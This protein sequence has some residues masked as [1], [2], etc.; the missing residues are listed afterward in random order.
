MNFFCTYFDWNY[1]HKGLVMLR[2]L[3]AQCA[4]Y[5]V[6]VLALDDVIKDKLAA[7][8]LPNVSIIAMSSFEDDELR[9]TRPTRSSRE[10]YWT[11]TPGWMQFVLQNGP[12]DHVNYIDADLMFFSD[13]QP[14]FDEIGGYSLAITP[15]DFPSR[16]RHMEGNGKY[17]V[18]LVHAKKD[19]DGMACIAEWKRLCLEWCYLRHEPNRPD[20]FCDQKYWDSVLEKRWHVHAIEHPGANRAPWNAEHR[21]WDLRGHLLHIDGKPLVWWHYHGYEG[22]HMFYPSTY[23]VSALQ[24]RYV[25]EPYLEQIRRSHGDVG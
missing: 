1:R 9:A 17:N 21:H 8:R 5:H 6:W 19:A 12:V 3:E 2:S 24:R 18:G 16:L 10:F 7:L 25:Y 11:C 23:I 4:D 14:V 22:A 13:P 15:H 20:R